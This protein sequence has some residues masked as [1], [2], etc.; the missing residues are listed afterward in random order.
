M[1]TLIITNYWYP[2]NHPCTIRWIN[3]GK[4]MDFDVLTQRVPRSG[5]KDYTLPQSGKKVIKF[6]WKLPAVLWGFLALIPALLMRYD[7]YLITAPPE[8][9]IF[10]AM[11]LKKLG[12][13]VIL[14]M[15]DSIERP[16][17]PHKWLRPL[18]RI[19]YRSVWTK[20]VAWR[21]IDANRPVICHG[22]DNIKLKRKG[23]PLFYRSRVQYKDYLMF[24]SYGMFPDF[25]SKPKRYVASSAHTVVRLGFK[26]NQKLADEQYGQHSWEE[27]AKRFKKFL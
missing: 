1:K 15:R 26:P 16:H 2:W 8:S 24:A 3:F 27:G 12:R 19:C 11:V 10:T 13:K 17:A 4:Y 18:W 20:I 23:R 6:G 9:L 5:F 21:L 7:S 22:Y 14:D 25:S